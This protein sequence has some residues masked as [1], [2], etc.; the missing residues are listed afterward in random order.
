MSKSFLGA[1]KDLSASRSC[2]LIALWMSVE[3]VVLAVEVVEDVSMCSEKG[4]AALIP[5]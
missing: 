2:L 1:G 4:V 5:R 3:E